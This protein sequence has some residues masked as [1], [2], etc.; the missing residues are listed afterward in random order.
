[1]DRKELEQTISLLIDN[2]VNLDDPEGKYAILLKDGRKID[3]KSFNY[4]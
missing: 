2:L 4:W 3:N 1:M